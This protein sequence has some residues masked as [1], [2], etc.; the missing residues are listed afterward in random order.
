MTS[1]F[2][3]ATFGKIPLR[4][5]LV[6]APMT[7]NRATPE[8]A[9][10]A[11]MAEYYAQRATSGLIITEGVQP[12][13]V[14]QG[15]INTPGLHTPEQVAS[16]RTVTDAV[17]A[18]GGRIVVQLMHSGRIGHPSL[19]ASAHEP[20]A[21]SPVRAAGQQFTPEGMQDY[22]VPRELTTAEIDATVRDFADAARNA[23]EAGFDGVQIH[24][25]NGFL[26]HQFLSEN[27]NHRT[28]AYG[29]SVAH[30]IRFTVEVTEAVAAA[31]G[32]EH[33]AVRVSPGNPY[34][35]IAEGDTEALYAA[36]VPALPE[37]AFLEVCEIVTRPVTRA[38]RD[39][40]RGNLVVNPHAAPDSFP[41]TAR[42]AQEVLDDG[43]ADAVS[44]GALFLA[45][46]DLP[47]RIAADGPYNDVDDSTFYGGDHRGYTDYPTLTA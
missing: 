30:R 6:M 4:N 18:Q 13:Q 11:L 40:W 33:T 28:D 20:V 9:A 26:L 44:L 3:A 19:Y 7:R 41:A 32:N 14:G 38:V 31:V 15:F 34:N 5:R 45:N 16:W 23:M 42:T 24:A 1:L 27:T 10:T 36:L 29:G 12:S 39:L 37:L 25:G 22:V 21:P 35:D 2:D 17:H 47:A 8:G 46:P 43:L